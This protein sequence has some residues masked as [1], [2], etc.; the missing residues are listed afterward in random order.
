MSTDRKNIERD[1]QSLSIKL[2]LAKEQTARAFGTDAI[3]YQL[4]DRALTNGGL[5]RGNVA[6]CT[7]R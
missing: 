4:I 6:S 5:Q 3:L 7:S 1:I 2:E